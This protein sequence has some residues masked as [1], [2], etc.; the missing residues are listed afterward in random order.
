MVSEDCLQVGAPRTLCGF[1]SC[2][3]RSVLVWTPAPLSSAYR[4][5]PLWQRACSHL[6]LVLLSLEGLSGCPAVRLMQ[7]NGAHSGAW[8]LRQPRLP[9]QDVHPIPDPISNLSS[10]EVEPCPQPASQVSSALE[11]KLKEILQVLLR[12]K[13]MLTGRDAKTR[14]TH[15][16]VRPH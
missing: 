15:R 7:G 8:P 6:V 16:D 9:L 3:A 13:A 2:G 4:P 11:E 10:V 12:V 1:S 14:G 5:S